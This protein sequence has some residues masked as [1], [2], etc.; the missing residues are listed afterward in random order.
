[1][2]S[3]KV[4][5]PVAYR[6]V[7]T[8]AQCLLWLFYRRIDVLGGDEVPLDRPLVVAANHHNSIVDALIV[9]AKFPRPVTILANAPLF[10]H[11]LLGPF[12]KAVG[13]V[14]VF[15]RKEAG[16]D[17]AKNASM[18]EAV[19]EVLHRRG[20]VLIFPEGRTQPKPQLLPLRTGAARIVTQCDPSER[21][22]L[23]PVGLVYHDPGTFRSGR[24]VI[25]VGSAIDAN[26][27]NPRNDHQDPSRVVALTKLLHQAIQAQIVEA[28]DQYTLDLLDVLEHFWRSEHDAVMAKNAPSERAA[29]SLTWRQHIMSCARWLRES[30]PV[31]VHQF[32]R[33][34]ELF[35]AHLEEVGLEPDQLQEP[36]DM[37]RTLRFV[38]GS[39]LWLGVGLPLALW[40]MLI[41]GLPYLLT[42]G[43]VRWMQQTEE[44]IATDKLAVGLVLYPVAWIAE[45]CVCAWL[46]DPIA[47][48]VFAVLLVPSGLFACAW[49][50]RLHA[51]ARQLSALFRMLTD[52]GLQM[53][54][55][56]ESHLLIA[57]LDRLVDRVP[58]SA[59]ET[60]GESNA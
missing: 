15:R 17:P 22:A 44:E 38:G 7:R 2:V 32:K 43:V 3:E 18:F 8:I 13:A 41:H 11:F 59:L 46:G 54:L 14:P 36:Y 42:D 30:D 9:V 49:R 5:S 20:A 50:E 60:G 31:A 52:R 34:L 27:H 21:T 33:R 24:A 39:L 40:G 25:N 56:D 23:L 53:R 45:A 6:V 29:H 51:V 47:L 19:L 57:E 26:A 48:I 28:D 55:M 35:R 1:M 16:D 4:K 12:L 58:A 37:S 10:T